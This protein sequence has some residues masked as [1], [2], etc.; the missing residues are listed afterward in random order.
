[1][2]IQVVE[3]IYVKP[4]SATCS[5]LGMHLDIADLLETNMLGSFLIVLALAL[6]MIFL[7]F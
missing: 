3:C 4:F 7:L 2:V 5:M 6:L 1:M